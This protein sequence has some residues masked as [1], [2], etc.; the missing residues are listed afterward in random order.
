M[1]NWMKEEKIQLSPHKRMQFLLLLVVCVAEAL[2]ITTE[3]MFHFVGYYLADHYI[4]V[5]CFLFLGTVLVQRL[6]GAAK[7]NLCLSAT[8]ALW[9]V[10]AQIRHRILGM[11]AVPGGYFFLSYLMAFPFA[12]VMEDYEKNIG[13]KLVTTLFLVAAL[14][15]V[16]YSALL[17]LDCVP[18]FM[19]NYVYW[20]G[21]RLH[22][23]WHSNTSA[24]IF[25][26]GIG[27]SLSYMF[28]TKKN[29]KKVLLTGSV[30][31]QFLAMSL[32]NG[33]TAVMMTCA[34]IGFAV[35]L[36]IWQEDR[37]R[38]LM[39]AAAALMTTAV[40]FVT[41]GEI[42]DLNQAWH[43]EQAAIQLQETP[44]NTE[45]APTEPQVTTVYEHG[46]AEEPVI[47]ETQ[48][49]EEAKQE[50]VLDEETGTVVIHGDSEQGTLK[51]DLRTLN[52]R[53]RIWRAAWTAVKNDKTQRWWGT[54]Y[55]GTTI[56]A[57]GYVTVEHA[58]NSWMEMLMSLGIPGLVFALIY[59]GIALWS[60]AVLLLK[61]TVAYWK[62]MIAVLLLCILVAAFLEPF[63]FFTKSFYQFVDFVFFFFLGYLDLWRRQAMYP[64]KYPEKQTE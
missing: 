20:D 27:A 45:P 52:G 25:M 57:N 29:W 59:T 54:S 7:C 30:F 43:L 16:G 9:F 8:A 15:L 28:H 36:A 63:L 42:Y 14:T 39:G 10:L 33:R 37:K 48:T 60:A 13:M 19:E 2:F 41:A 47:Q 21:T 18:D 61:K 23:L 5:P 12:S 24:C 55:V 1:K 53:T 58:H 64:E 32:T 40:L 34:L 38:F 56:S 4:A 6:S 3:G 35:F 50:I 46:S 31:L 26:I 11:E 49:A 44:E 62:K 17:V 22:P 51:S